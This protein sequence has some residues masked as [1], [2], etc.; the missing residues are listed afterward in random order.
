MHGAMKVA[1]ILAAHGPITIP[2]HGQMNVSDIGACKFAAH[3]L[4]FKKKLDK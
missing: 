1:E 4:L 3:F 2:P